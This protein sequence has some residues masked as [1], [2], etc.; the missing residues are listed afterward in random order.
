MARLL[1][2]AQNQYLEWSGATPPITAPPFTLS[3]WF[4]TNTDV[5]DQVLM[6]IGG[7]FL[8]NESDCVASFL[9]QKTKNISN[10]P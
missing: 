7:R 3:C 8:P 2:D 10:T 1:D 4:Y 9:R 5:V 6:W